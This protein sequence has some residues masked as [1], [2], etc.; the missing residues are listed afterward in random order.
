MKCIDDVSLKKAEDIYIRQAVKIDPLKERVSTLGF[1]YFIRFKIL[2]SMITLFPSF[3][4][5][6]NLLTKM[7]QQV[8]KLLNP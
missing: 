3:N 8:Y 4:F 2:M 6:R 5:Q 7:H 1:L